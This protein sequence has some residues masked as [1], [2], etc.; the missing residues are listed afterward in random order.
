MFI[1]YVIALDTDALSSLQSFDV[2]KA[3]PQ[4]SD[5]RTRLMQ[6]GYQFETQIVIQIYPTLAHYLNWKHHYVKNPCSFLN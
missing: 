4:D 2:D 5:K 6:K 3:L 1:F